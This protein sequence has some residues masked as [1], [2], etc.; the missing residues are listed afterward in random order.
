MCRR[1]LCLMRPRPAELVVDVC[2]WG[3]W[4]GNRGSQDPGGGR[5]RGHAVRPTTL[6][7]QTCAI[8]TMSDASYDCALEGMNLKD[9]PQRSVVLMQSSVKLIG[10]LC[11]S[12]KFNAPIVASVTCLRCDFS[13]SVSTSMLV[14]DDALSQ[15]GQASR[16]PRKF[17]DHV[18]PNR[19]Q[20]GA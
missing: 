1:R 16:S 20:V 15:R 10:S 5:G 8:W 12:C 6:P 9:W 19:V 2:P 18:E 17:R 7:R 13:G 3:I 11:Q 4:S 14:V